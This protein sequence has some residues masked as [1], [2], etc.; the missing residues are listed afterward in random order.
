[1][2]P[3][4]LN[5]KTTVLLGNALFTAGLFFESFQ[6]TLLNFELQR[7]VVVPFEKYGHCGEPRLSRDKLR[8]EAIPH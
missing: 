7:R 6:N 2:S 5:R 3:M 4:E 1:M 8:D